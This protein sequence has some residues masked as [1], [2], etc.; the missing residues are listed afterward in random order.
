MNMNTR[1][2][3]GVGVLSFGALLTTTSQAATCNGVTSGPLGSQICTL[4]GPNLTWI[5]AIDGPG[6][7]QTSGALAL[8][9]GPTLIGDNI[10]FLPPNFKAESMNG[11]GVA[12][13]AGNFVFTRVFTN[14]GS[15][16]IL[17]FAS[18]D[19][20]DYAITGGLNVAASLYLQAA[21]NT[22]ALRLA[23]A[24]TSFGAN[25]ST[26]GV[27]TPWNLTTIVDTT[28]PQPNFPFQQIVAGHDFA[29]NVQ[30]NLSASTNAANTD[31]WIQKK[32]NIDVL[33]PVPAAAWLFGSALL[34]L[35]GVKRRMAG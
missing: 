12:T 35:A 29:V 23:N 32:I 34:G 21:D 8:F 13:T 30:D 9:D 31:A 4:T 28:T 17:G 11:A 18:A 15:N 33:V 2:L 26:G 16:T 14:N 10:R 1:Q 27:A 3:I 22:N 25:V 20:G 24:T 6:G 5:Y 19:I 7:M